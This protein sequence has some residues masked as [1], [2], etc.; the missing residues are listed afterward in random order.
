[1]REIAKIKSTKKVIFISEDEELYESFRRVLKFISGIETTRAITCND[2]NHSHKN[3][4]CQIIDSITESNIEKSVIFL[5]LNA[6]SN[7]I[8]NL[9]AQKKEIR[10]VDSGLFYIIVPFYLDDLLDKINYSDPITNEEIIM[11]IISW[12]SKESHDIR[13][14]LS[15]IEGKNKCVALINQVFESLNESLKL[16]QEIIAEKEG[17]SGL[18]TDSSIS[19]DIIANNIMTLFQKLESRIKGRSNKL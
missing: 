12:L 8:I 13:N 11:F 5:R 6:C 7:P 2:L 15:N 9:I 1:M 16:P 4:S 3:V 17:V 19:K 18:I 10:F 14:M